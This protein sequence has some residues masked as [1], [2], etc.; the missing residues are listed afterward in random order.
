MRERAMNVLLAA[1]MVALL[2]LLLAGLLFAVIVAWQVAL[3]ERDT[4]RAE[5]ADRHKALQDASPDVAEQTAVG[6]DPWGVVAE[7][8]ANARRVL[9]TSEEGQ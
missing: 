2:T 3:L 8:A 9:D 1:Y 5:A 4:A 7:Y 6:D